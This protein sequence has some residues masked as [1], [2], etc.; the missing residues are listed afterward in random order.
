[1]APPFFFVHPA[2]PLR[3]D[4]FLKTITV[5]GELVEPQ[6]LSGLPAVQPPEKRGRP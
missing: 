3:L 1:M 4:F 6:Q 5:R 2:T